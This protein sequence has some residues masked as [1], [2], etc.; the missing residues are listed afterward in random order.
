MKQRLK[1]YFAFTTR[2]YCILVLLVFPVLIIAGNVF[3]KWASGGHV[4]YGVSLTSSFLLVEIVGNYL[5]SG[6]IASKQTEKLFY[7][8]SS[9]RG[10][11]LLKNVL[12]GDMMRRFLY[13]LLELLCVYALTEI[14]P[15]NG[16]VPDVGYGN[17]MLAFSG[18][19]FAGYFYGT[20]GITIA[21]FFDSFRVAFVIWYLF[22]LPVSINCYAMGRFPESYAIPAVYLLLS[23]LISI[24]SIRSVIKRLRSEPQ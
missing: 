6:G 1:C 8:K 10:E 24:F 15:S 17:R 2:L 5:L 18:L 11:Q 7:L 20:L 19:L 13:F 12:A 16:A 14:L 22:F 21:R 4:I 23:I 9:A 3:V